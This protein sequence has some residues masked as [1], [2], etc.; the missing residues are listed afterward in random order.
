MKKETK[1]KKKMKEYVKSGETEKYPDNES[2]ADSDNDTRQPS[3]KKKAKQSERD[4]VDE[5]EKKFIKDMKNL[6]KE[7]NHR[8]RN[9]QDDLSEETEKDED[10]KTIELLLS[11]KGSKYLVKWKNLSSDENTWEQRTAIPN[12][13]LS[14]R[15]FKLFINP[16]LYILVL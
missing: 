13:I 11:K 8:E 5:C 3:K 2:F 9:T 6:E 16:L 15:N 4:S 10:A 12:R 7:S 1:N 14:V